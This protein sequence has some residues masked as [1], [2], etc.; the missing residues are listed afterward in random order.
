M[1]EVFSIIDCKV[2]L[3]SLGLLLDITGAILIYVYGIQPG[4][5]K[6]IHS[7]SLDDMITDK[8]GKKD[9]L[10]SRFKKFSFTGLLILITGFLLQLASNFL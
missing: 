6:P 9:A 2:F 3:N 10:F 7:F 8:E 1:I 4:L 5:S